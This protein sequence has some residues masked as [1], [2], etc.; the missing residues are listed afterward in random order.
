LTTESR[1]FSAAM[2]RSVE[3]G[4]HR[5]AG[6]HSRAHLDPAG[7]SA[8]A[9]SAVAAAAVVAEARLISSAAI[10]GVVVV[11][12]ATR[13]MRRAHGNARSSFLGATPPVRARL[14]LVP[15]R[16]RFN[17]VL[18]AQHG[19]GKSAFPRAEPRRDEPA[20][21]RSATAGYV[22]ACVMMRGLCL[23]LTAARPAR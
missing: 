19:A 9:A 22:S 5:S 7:A 14:V 16:A 1:R 12:A 11:A 21:V 3:V 2:M 8:A 20:T 18:R 23:E 13:R 4:I 15:H 6:G 10:L 17:E